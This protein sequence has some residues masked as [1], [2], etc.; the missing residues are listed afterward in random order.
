MVCHVLGLNARVP[1]TN[2]MIQDNLLDHCLL[3]Y[4][5]VMSFAINLARLNYKGERAKPWVAHI[6]FFPII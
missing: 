2:Y 1:F 4:T 5:D 3:N 6:D